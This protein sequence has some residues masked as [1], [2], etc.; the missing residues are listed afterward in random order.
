MKKSMSLF[1]GCLV[2]LGT[3]ACSTAQKQEEQS[4][5]ISASGEGVQEEST[6]AFTDSSS[7]TS[8]EESTETAAAEPA[9]M[10][11]EPLAEV[12]P[13]PPAEMPKKSSRSSTTSNYSLGAGSSGRGH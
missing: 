1:L 10:A 9:P 4:T 2:L 3:S 6:D 12:A 13:E 7:S 5:D 8:E 11:S